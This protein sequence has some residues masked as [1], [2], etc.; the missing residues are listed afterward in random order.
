[1]RCVVGVQKI[2]SGEVIVPGQPA[3][4]PALRSRV[5]YVTRPRR[6]TP[7]F[8]SAPTSATTPRST[9]LPR[10]TPTGR[11]LMSSFMST[12]WTAIRARQAQPSQSFIGDGAAPERPRPRPGRRGLPAPTAPRRTGSGQ[13]GLGPPRRPPRHRRLRHHPRLRDQTQSRT[14]QS[15]PQHQFEQDPLKDGTAV[16]SSGPASRRRQRV[17]GREPC[18]PRLR[19]PGGS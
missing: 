16:L 15:G 1:M 7:T 13:R 5:G 17:R 6:C 18:R 14:R 3:G 9:E 11:S 8:P 4:T 2:A 12:P 19:L 10:P